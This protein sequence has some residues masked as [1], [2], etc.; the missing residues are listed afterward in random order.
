MNRLRL[1]KS[2]NNKINMK[3]MSSISLFSTNTSDLNKA[4]IAEDTSNLNQES[5]A[6]S[7]LL[8]EQT[9]IQEQL[10]IINKKIDNMSEK[11]NK[12]YEMVYACDNGILSMI[13]ATCLIGSVILSRQK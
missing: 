10:S 12:I 2:I 9:S 13:V 3:Y 11:Q 1:A 4:P 7:D 6:K 5:V 8:L